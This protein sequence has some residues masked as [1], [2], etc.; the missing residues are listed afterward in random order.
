MLVRLKMTT[1]CLNSEEMNEATLK[2]SNLSEMDMDLENAMDSEKFLEFFN[3]NNTT[4]RT[5]AQ[6]TLR[7]PSSMESYRE[8]FHLEIVCTT[9]IADT[10]A[11][12]LF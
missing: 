4:I 9:W 2:A 1:F 8:E 11:R 6:I 7:S 12:G 5:E 3:A 10:Q